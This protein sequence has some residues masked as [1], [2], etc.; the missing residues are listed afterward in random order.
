MQQRNSWCAVVLLLA[1]TVRCGGGSDPAVLEDDRSV[2][3]VTESLRLGPIGKALDYV[4]CAQE[5]QPCAV[6]SA[7]VAFGANGSYFYR[8]ALGTFTCNRD[9]FGGDPIVGTPKACYFANYSLIIREGGVVSQPAGLSTEIAYGARGAFT[10]KRVTGTYTCNNNTFDDPIVG[11]R[12]ECF[13][14]LHDYAPDVFENDTMTVPV[15][16][17]IAFGANGK[18]V[19]KI[20]PGGSHP[21]TVAA[22]GNDDPAPNVPK[23]CYRAPKNRIAIEDQSTTPPPLENGVPLVYYG[24]GANGN[25]LVEVF[26]R[27]FVCNNDAFGGDP[28]PGHVKFCWVPI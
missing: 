19:Y 11:T 20:V 16:S 22:F 28:D 14:P 6:G 13:L 12:K 4:L 1:G 17:A 2:G 25:F 24:S 8:A 18:F 9:F 27:P 5:D 21:C 26:L 3:T 10:F 15:D 7:Y 23:R